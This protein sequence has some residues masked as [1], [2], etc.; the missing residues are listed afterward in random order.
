[1]NNIDI[2]DTECTSMDYYNITTVEN[3][4]INHNSTITTIATEIFIC[5]DELD[6]ELIVDT[7]P[8]T[9]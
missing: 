4:D 1:M 7:I 2:S 9:S 3:D 8:T 6:A 5:N